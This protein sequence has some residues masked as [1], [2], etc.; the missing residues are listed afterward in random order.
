MDKYSS[1]Y[2]DH[3]FVAELYDPVYERLARRDI[4]FF[5]DYAKKAKGKTL[6]L[7]CGTGRVLIPTAQA[8]CEIT[9]LDFSRFML[10][11][12]REKL[13]TTST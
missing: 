8:G 1:G 12:C 13:A 5:V 6:E 2:E 7:G 10:E 3:E 4:E 9:G 11:K